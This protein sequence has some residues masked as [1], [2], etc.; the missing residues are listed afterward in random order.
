MQIFS[1]IKVVI[2]NV[3]QLNLLKRKLSN[4]HIFKSE[5]K[6]LKII[7]QYSHKAL[8]CYLKG[9]TALWWFFTATYSRKKHIS[10]D[11]K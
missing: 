3:V 5:G 7:L 6:K 8:S 1:K 10:Y 9:A 11:F 2:I 4:V